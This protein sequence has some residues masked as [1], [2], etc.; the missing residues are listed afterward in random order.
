MATH[1]AVARP[2][3][4]ALLAATVLHGALF[5]ALSAR[6]QRP[7]AEALTPVALD[8]IELSIEVDVSAPSERVAS[9]EA[10]PD[11]P[12]AD[13]APPA[14]AAVD[15]G[16]LTD[17]LHASQL[18]PP[19][20]PTGT[21]VAP[22][23]VA[24]AALSP[25]AP[26]PFG[27]APG[28]APGDRGRQAVAGLMR[29]GG[30]WLLAP[31]SGA[32]P[33]PVEATGRGPRRDDDPDKGGRLLRESL[34]RANAARGLGF[35]GPVVGAAQTAVHAPGAP[36]QGK[37][38]FEVVTDATGAIVSITPRGAATGGDWGPVLAALRAQLAGRKL[39]VPEGANGV[40]VVV[41]VEAKQQMPSGKG[42]GSGP[43]HMTGP[44]SG[45]FDVADIGAKVARVVSARIVNERRL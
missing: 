33:A 24:S 12:P 6:A 19:T 16:R 9:P 30:S 15:P 25:F 37:A 34:D 35:G 14:A 43:V 3:S 31:G 45:E 20:A 21:E 38:S 23:P 10:Q 27:D 42:E 32:A 18:P 13:A 41:Q 5:G 7:A 8:A 40:A 28:E 17:R 1:P 4:K 39:R 11:S 29:G 36:S 44:V 2:F 26:S 22:A